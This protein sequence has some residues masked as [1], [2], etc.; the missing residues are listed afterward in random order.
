M[1]VRS[2]SSHLPTQQ[3][4]NVHQNEAEEV[5]ILHFHT[6]VCGFSVRRVCDVLAGQALRGSDSRFNL[7]LEQDEVQ[8]GCNNT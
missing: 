2:S 3:K 7:T 5:T 1:D 4:R 6:K 8:S